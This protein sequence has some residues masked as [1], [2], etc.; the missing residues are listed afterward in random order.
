MKAINTELIDVVDY[1]NSKK[2]PFLLKTFPEYKI[3]GVNLSKKGK[4]F[5]ANG[6]VVAS[7]MINSIQ[8]YTH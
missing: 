7:N 3:I 6:K 2:V 5:M 1:L 8:K 4:F